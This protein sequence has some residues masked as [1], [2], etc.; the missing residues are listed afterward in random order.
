[1]WKTWQYQT[2]HRW[3]YNTAYPLCKPDNWGCKHTLEV[4]DTSCVSPSKMVNGTRHNI[5]LYV[6]CPS[7]LSLEKPSNPLTSSL[8]SLLEKTGRWII[9]INCSVCTAILK[10]G[11]RH[12]ICCLFNVDQYQGP[13][14]EVIRSLFHPPPTATICFV[15][16]HPRHLL[17][18]LQTL[19]NKFY[20]R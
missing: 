9:V 12:R 14:T 3:Q 17:L 19:E 10:H 6:H 1:M 13:I 16:I 15:T 20:H 8:L 7:C 4:C 18:G 11:I 2:V 5:T